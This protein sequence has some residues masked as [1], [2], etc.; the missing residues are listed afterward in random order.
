MSPMGFI[1]ECFRFYPT[2]E[3]GPN[4]WSR[5]CVTL[6]F[7]D[8]GSVEWL[9]DPDFARLRTDIAALKVS[10]PEGINMKCLN[11]TP[12]NFSNLM[13]FVGFECSIVGFPQPK[14]GGLMTPIWR[15][16]TLAS[17]PLLPVDDKPMFL[18]DAATSPGFSGGPVF[19]RHI[20]PAPVASSD[21]SIAVNLDRV[22]TTS[23]VGVY[24][25]RL[26]HSHYGGEVPFV[27]YGN[28]IPI[29]LATSER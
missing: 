24:A 14:L 13:S 6:D 23:F 12:D 16:G 20:G 19:R 27:F 26:S 8:D 2:V 5:R 22:L 9:E 4:Q 11:D 21:G 29:I 25:G 3:V 10:P 18:L 7:T 28:R 1:P 17:E 15:R